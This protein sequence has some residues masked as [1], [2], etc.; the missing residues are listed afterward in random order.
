MQFDIDFG[1]IAIDPAA[2]PQTVSIDHESVV[3]CPPTYVCSGTPSYGRPMAQGAPNTMVNITIN[4]TATLSDGAGHTLTFTPTPVNSYLS[5]NEAGVRS[6]R[7][8]GSIDFTGDE[9]AG[10]YSTA[11]AGGSGY[12]ITVNY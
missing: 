3:T 10:V 8:S 6:W 4:S 11:N 2:G 9:A 7:V 12:T 5:L 1:T